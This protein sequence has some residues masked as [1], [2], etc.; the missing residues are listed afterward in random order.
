MARATNDLQAVRMLC[1]P[2]I[3]YSANTLFVATG[4]LFF[5]VRIHG[6]LTLLALSTMPLVAV[7]TQV[8]GARIHVLFERV[9][10]SFSGLSTRAQENISGIRVV[11][12]YAQEDGEREAFREANR[13]YVERNRHLIRW[14]AA[15]HPLI[16]ALVGIGFVAVL[17]YGGLLVTRGAVTV[18]QFVT[19]TFFL[20]K[21]IWPMVAIGWVINLVQRGTASLGRIRRVLEEP[22]EISDDD[23]VSDP[24]PLAG[25]VAFRGLDFAYPAGGPRRPEP[26]AEPASPEGVQDTER[27]AEPGRAA[28]S[29]VLEGIDLA[30]PAGSTV[31]VVGRTGAGKSTLLS[32]VPRLI[33]PPPGT[34]AIDGIDVRRIPLRRLREAV[35]MVPQESFL[36]SATLRD[37]IAFGRPDAAAE[38][39]D[40]AAELAGLHEDLESFP[41][42]L[43]TLVGERGITLSGGQKQRVALARAL[44]CDPRILLLDD[45]LSAVD[46]QTEER[47]LQNLRQVFEGRTVFLVAHR[48]STVQSADLILVLEH[49]RI[50]DRGTHEELTARGGL[51]ADLHQR[52]LLEDELAAVS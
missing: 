27:A 15:F 41:K 42:A 28:V 4:A 24:G 29:P 14:T 2:A 45:C 5:M 47:I 1:G 9:Q 10:E 50:V 46:T 3:M 35:A 19:F 7:A 21:L 38:D 49:G 33:D 43:E 40:R 31:A 36:F 17:W 22:P 48:I 44:L 51:Y 18:G 52:Q 37:N 20:T 23:A 30:V 13:D 12:A 11:R 32:L 8:V 25:A 16:Q 6:P 34:L 26:V 39:V